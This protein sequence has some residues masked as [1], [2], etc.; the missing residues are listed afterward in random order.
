MD[1]TIFDEWWEELEKM[2]AFGEII[3]GITLRDV[4]IT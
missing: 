2:W 1:R 3:E 4:T